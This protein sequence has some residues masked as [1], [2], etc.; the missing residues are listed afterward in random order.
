MG[1]AEK[2]TG[3]IRQG[4][5]TGETIGYSPSTPAL[6]LTTKPKPFRP[7]TLENP[8]QTGPEPAR[9][10]IETT[11][12]GKRKPNLSYPFACF[13]WRLCLLC[14]ALWRCGKPSQDRSKGTGTETGNLAEISGPK[15]G[16]MR[17]RSG[18][19]QDWGGK[20]NVWRGGNPPS[21]R[22]ISPSK[23][24]TSSFSPLFLWSFDSRQSTLKTLV[25]SNE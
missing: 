11:Q 21:F 12:H 17:E 7:G 1:M 22:P 15:T 3:Q 16:T 2:R 8:S 4:I 14:F 6:S 9:N 13:T 5:M 20:R 10:P 25:W 24:L 23:R 18:K 19:G